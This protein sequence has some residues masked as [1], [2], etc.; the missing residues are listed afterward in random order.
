MNCPKCKEPLR[1]EIY[2]KNDYKICF[3]CEGTW[4]TGKNL[5][6]T[7]I[8]ETLTHTNTKTDY[9][10]PN[11]A[12]VNLEKSYSEKIELE[13]CPECS[14]IFFDTGELEKSHPEYK[15]A[16]IEEIKSD[17]KKTITAIIAIGLTIKLLVKVFNRE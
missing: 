7:N 17:A 14:G 3:Y 13:Y 8:V 15:D 11:C 9:E 16:D 12:G 6:N 2:R 1:N 5:K 10:C 4:L